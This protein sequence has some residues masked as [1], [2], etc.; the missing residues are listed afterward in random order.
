[1]TPSLFDA[2]IRWISWLKDQKRCSAR[3][4]EAYAHALRYYFD[5]LS[6]SLRTDLTLED[7][8]TV[9]SGDI[10]GWMA[11]LRGKDEPLSARSLAQ[12]LSAIKSFHSFLDLHFDMP[13]AQ[14]ALMRGPRLKATLPRP[15]TQDQ[16]L[17]LLHE[18]QMDSDR[19]D[20]ENA[21][22]E[23]VYMLLYGLG[24]RISEALSL[25]VKDA[26][27][28]DTLRIVGKGNKMRALPVLAAV[29]DA[30]EA[31]RAQQPFTLQPEDK[32]FRAKRGGELSPR[33]VQASVQ[34]LRSRLGLSDRA[35]P[36]ALRHSFATHLLG[37]G[38]DLRSIQELLGHVS[39]S[40]TQ[41]YTQVD[42]EKLLSAYAAA[43]P[44]G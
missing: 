22:D 39:L 20:W 27:L 3:T 11:H 24:L 6:T 32:L 41:K 14:V 4:L 43:H 5:H 23:A 42:T 30:I 36:H 28:G 44:K 12:H 34:H 31:Y 17:G 18:N 35:T 7:V 1:M 33:H 37:S 8:V 19:D 16:T 26:P 25:Q 10:R 21:R 13:N 40:T 29:R 9:S 15:L 38:A 2:Q